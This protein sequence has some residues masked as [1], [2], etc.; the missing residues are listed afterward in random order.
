MVQYLGLTT[1][2]QTTLKPLKLENAILK[3]LFQAEKRL[4]KKLKS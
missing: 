2:T 1:F 3:P 4:L